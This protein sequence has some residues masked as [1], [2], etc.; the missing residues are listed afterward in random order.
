MLN[1]KLTLVIF[2]YWL[3]SLIKAQIIP[4]LSNYIPFREYAN[5]TKQ[6]ISGPRCETYIRNQLT[7]YTSNGFYNPK[8]APMII[9]VTPIFQNISGNFT[10]VEYGTKN[11][12]ISVFA[13][14]KSFTGLNI[15]SGSM[16]MVLDFTFLWLK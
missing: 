1:F 10:I 14:F 2:L 16:S 6:S 4:P 7:S 9:S 5:C 12:N 15:E 13:T 3:T 11:F 8:T